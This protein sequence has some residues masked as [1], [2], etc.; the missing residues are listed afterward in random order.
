MRS[1][2]RTIRRPRGL[3]LRLGPSNGGNGEQRTPS[4][5]EA[6]EHDPSGEIGSSARRVA[7]RSHHSRA[8][9]IRGGDHPERNR[10]SSDEKTSQRGERL[11]RP[12][13]YW[14]EAQSR[15]EAEGTS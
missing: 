7:R 11:P 13:G 1:A 9:G 14:Y 5:G 8:A 3:R 2:S 10:A 12:N 15:N 4:H 6:G